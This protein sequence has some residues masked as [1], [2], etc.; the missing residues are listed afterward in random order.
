MKENLLLNRDLFTTLKNNFYK[1]M[2][3][4]PNNVYLDKITY[5][6]IDEYNNTYYRATKMKLSDVKSGIYIS[7]DI[8]GY[9]GRF[10][11][12]SLKSKKNYSK[13]F[14]KLKKQKKLH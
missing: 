12:P 8:W 9:L 4:I 3:A 1:Y 7:S 2:T 14:P 6:I 10:P 13:N 11:D 5:K